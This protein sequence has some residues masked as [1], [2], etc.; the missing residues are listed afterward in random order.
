MSLSLVPDPEPPLRTPSQAST[1]NYLLEALGLPIL[2][3]HQQAACRAPDV[4]PNWFF[5]ERG[6]RVAEARAVCARC[7][8]VEECRAAGAR[9]HFGI[10]GG[11]SERQRRAMRKTRP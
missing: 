6:E 11:T 5:P 2:E 3:W 7:P 10:W 1:L 4:D 8:V 9:E